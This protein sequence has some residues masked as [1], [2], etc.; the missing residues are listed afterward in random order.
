M[1]G[2]GLGLILHHKSLGKVFE[3]RCLH[4]PVYDRT[5][6]RGLVELVEK[7]IR[8]EHALSPDKPIYVV[9]DSF[10]GCLAL[11][12][13]ARCPTIDLVL[14]LSNP[15][16]SMNRGHLK[17][18]IPIMEA[19]PDQLHKALPYLISPMLGEAN[20]MAMVNVDAKL[21]PISVLKQM[22]ANLTSLL[23]RVS[24]LAD[25]IPKDTLVWKFKLL[26]S[27][28]NYT[29]PRLHAVKAEV[30]VL[31][32]GKDNILPSEDEAKRLSRV[33]KNCEFRT[34]CNNGHTLLLED[35]INLL[36]VIKATG[37]YRRSRKVDVVLD[38]IPPSLQENKV[39]FDNLTRFIQYCTGPVI[40]STLEDGK[41]V[42]GLSGVPSEGPVLLVGYHMLMGLELSGIY[43]AFLSEKKIILRGLAHPELLTLRYS[44][45]IS[46]SDYTRIFGATPVTAKNLFKLLSNNSHVLLY[47]GGAREA[48]HLRGEEYKLIWPDRQ[49]F[50]RMAAKF[51]ATI[52]P[53]S[54]VGED[55]L[56]ELILD[57]DDY[58]KIPVV[59]DLIRLITSQMTRVRNGMDGEVGNE[60]LYMPGVL[61]KLPGRFY[62]LFAK[63]IETRG[64]QELLKDKEGAEELYARIKSEIMSG[65]AYLLE[66]REEDPYRSHIDR[67]MYRLFTEKMDFPTFSP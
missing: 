59:N 25:I 40:L 50:V 27:A 44:N 57:Y 3:V 54:V 52:V 6:F 7:A 45:E 8:K 34:F 61:P 19:L 10:G 11:A 16:T 30:L 2:V 62:Y 43:D 9:G 15:A 31:A 39:G 49:E 55:D 20:K 28:A 41:I 12:V 66:K 37:K 22:V 26:K 29:N 33:L 17:P 58:M 65:I 36:T 51:G 53:F 47:P 13:A 64:N 32:S 23:P 14:I 63:P 5:P 35:G 56:V 48:L 24:I 38:F 60:N 4:I 67:I 18:L 21:P 42:R 1:D 46:Y